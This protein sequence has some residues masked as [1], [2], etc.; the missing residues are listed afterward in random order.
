MKQFKTTKIL[1]TAVLITILL[2]SASKANAASL[3]DALKL[4]NAN[5]NTFNMSDNENVSQD[6]GGYGKGSNN[7]TI[8]GNNYQIIGNGYKGI[9]PYEQNLTINGVNN[10]GDIT[11]ATSGMS[12]FNKAI[13]F[14][15]WNRSSSL[16]ITDSFFNN[17]NNTGDGLG[18]AISTGY[19]SNAGKANV[20]IKDSV[21]K[22]NTA[23][24]FG[25]AIFVGANSIVTLGNV[26][27]INNTAKKG[28]EN[29]VRNDITNEGTLI[30]KNGLATDSLTTDITNRS[31]TGVGVVGFENTTMDFKDYSFKLIGQALSIDSTSSVTATSTSLQALNYVSNNGNFTF[32]A[33]SEDSLYGLWLWGNGITTFTEGSYITHKSG[34]SIGGDR[35]T[36]INNGYLELIPNLARG[37]IQNNNI[38][39]LLGTTGATLACHIS[40][41][42][43]TIVPE[44]KGLNS[45]LNTIVQNKLTIEQDATAILLLDKV[46]AAIDNDGSITAAYNG[47]PS[48]ANTITGDGDITFPDG[49]WNFVNTGSITQ[50][51][52]TNKLRTGF[53][54]SDAANLIT[55]N[56]IANSGIMYLYGKLSNN[57][58]GVT[59]TGVTTTGTVKINNQTDKNVLTINDDLSIAGIFDLNGQT[60]SMQETP[61]ET[62]KYS[63]LSVDNLKGIGNFKIDVNMAKNESGKA[64]ANDKL[65]VVL[66]ADTGTIL[67]LSDIKVANPIAA[68][69]RNVYTDYLTYLTGPTDNITMKIAGNTKDNTGAFLATSDTLN[70]YTFTLG[71]AGKLDVAIDHLPISISEYITGSTYDSKTISS[72]NIITD[73][74]V[75]L[76]IG[77]T[78]QG[79][80]R[81]G[82]YNLTLN[83]NNGADL[84]GARGID[85][86]TVAEGYSLTIDGSHTA[87]TEIKNFDTALINEDTLNV[88]S[89]TFTG[90][91][92]D[93]VNNAILN[94]DG[95]NTIGSGITGTDGTTN[96][97]TGTT[98]AN[99]TI[100]QK[101]INILSG[102]TLK[103]NA[104]NIIATETLDNK[105]TLELTG[106]N[107]NQNISGSTGTLNISGAV[108]N[109]ANKTINQ[110]DLTIGSTNSFST[111]LDKLTLTDGISNAGN[112]TLQG[113][114][115]TAVEQTN[116]ITGGGNTSFE[117]KVNNTGLISQDV[118]IKAGAEFTSSATN[119]SGAIANKGTYN[120]QTGTL[121]SVISDTG[122]I[123]LAS[124]EKLTINTG[125]SIADTQ[126]FNAGNNS[127]LSLIGAATS[128]TI[129]GLA[130]AANEAMNLEIDW[131]DTFNSFETNIAGIVKLSKIDVN[132]ATPTSYNFTNL[133]SNKLVLDSGVTLLN[134]SDTVNSVKIDSSG[135][136]ITSSQANLVT[137]VNSANSDKNIYSMTKDEVWNGSALGD[138][139]NITIDGKGKTITQTAGLTNTITVQNNAK[140]VLNNANTQTGTVVNL[141]GNSAANKSRIEIHNPDNLN[142]LN[143]HSDVIS[144]DS[145]NEIVFSGG[146]INANG[147]LDP[148]TSTLTA[149]ELNRGASSY[150]D[151][152]D[153]ILDAGT[154]KYANDKSL[155]DLLKHTTPVGTTP[156]TGEYHYNS[157]NFNGGALDMRNGVATPNMKLANLTVSGN[158]NLYLDVHLA[159]KKMDNFN[160]STVTY[161]AGT[162]NVAGLSLIS[163]AAEVN[164][165]IN[166][167]NDAN[168]MGHVAYTGG[169]NLT[170][171]SPI[172]KYNV[173][174][175]N[176]TGNFGFA[177]SGGYAGHNPSIYAGAIGAQVGSYLNQINVYEQS[178]ANMD[179]L[180]LMTKEQRQAMKMANKYAAST[181]NLAY[182]PKKQIPEEN[183]GAWLRPFATFENV[184]LKNGP[185]VGNTAYGSLFGGDTEILELKHGWDAVVSP[186][187]GYVGSHQTYDGVGIYQNGGVLGAT[188]AF[189][190]GNFFTGLTANAGANVGEASTM[191]GQD[192][193]TML[194]AGVA[195]KTGYNWELADGKFII[196]PSFL[197][198]YTFVNT[199]DY[200]TSNGVSIDS[201][202][203]NAIQIVPGLKFIGNLKNGWQPYASVQM[204][205]NII[206]DTKFKANDVS[207]EQLSVKPYIQYG[208]GV[209]KRWGERFTGYAQAMIRNG[210]RNGIALSAGFRWALG[211]APE[212][213]SEVD[214]KGAFMEKDPKH[215][216]SN[217]RVL[218]QNS[219]G[220]KNAKFEQMKKSSGAPELQNAK[221][222]LSS[223]NKTN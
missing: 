103:G 101:I 3:Y 128:A 127:T 182:D 78:A 159:A 129:N 153:W 208:L 49:W 165:T 177:R 160:G 85:G 96:V 188:A 61:A 195:S 135:K 74:T 145:A 173:A 43:E 136:L 122:I 215:Y 117:N 125:G 201:D 89:I 34:Q 97:K 161:T 9:T 193:F 10:T 139:N 106:G 56:D 24:G 5:P 90:N 29:G 192:D 116:A 25:G 202:P 176:S 48:N 84:I 42:G 79:D 144:T 37:T 220:A 55:T 189:Y 216:D 126:T 199:F 1:S 62:A 86:I 92:K 67:N 124:G 4:T 174:Y 197:M 150:D 178:F 93:I 190:K 214:A 131:G 109:T 80:N 40:G 168:L 20:S 94:L 19:S 75:P 68:T 164:T 104:D 223:L 198:S 130:I 133:S 99:S 52:I 163:D 31:G 72:L 209:Q 36:V 142:A 45:G 217:V 171:L 100:S 151:G 28:T 155:Y 60:L 207:L 118:E 18:G 69:D 183:K 205:W 54:T 181:A 169:Q 76:T 8:N 38:L 167:T 58:I 107:I 27:F 157:M 50:K 22:D 95:T 6:L 132:S 170:A 143:F 140:L 102:A 57:I 147:L 200:R 219:A 204:I 149:T 17:N 83:I 64:T 70:K 59:N 11:T 146:V 154:L 187:A 33:G 30:F 98:T 51:Y 47:A 162:L 180:M 156:P 13:S 21:F 91:I 213:K 81:K 15:G 211:K 71:N 119:I 148:A 121:N 44:G 35:G 172:Y 12:G 206:D 138:N 158:S 113:G 65:N 175:D 191:Y 26:K 23:T 88:N 184:G 114:T 186:F 14:G 203:L 87:G 112:L 120:I 53:F 210:G 222:N 32:S 111:A 46:T 63:T 110:K 194:T 2:F 41:T 7:F 179:M 73:T 185:D 134:T 152:M 221:F 66:G 212:K 77:T 82:G 39:K 137:A 218:S 105:G 123:N 16:T 196:Q 166:F 115:T 141:T 108:T